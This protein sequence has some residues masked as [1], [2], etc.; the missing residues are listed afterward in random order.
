MYNSIKINGMKGFTLIELM[1][2][3]VIIGILAAIAIPAYQDYIVRSRSVELTQEL[4][5]LVKAESIAF[6]DSSVGA[7]G[8]YQTPTFFAAPQTP[9]SVP[10][11]TKVVTSNWSSDPNWAKLGFSIS[12]PA[13]GTYEAYAGSTGLIGTSVVVYA[14][15][16]F[17]ADAAGDCL[18]AHAPT[19]CMAY[20]RDITIVNGGASASGL[21]TLGTGK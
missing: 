4:D 17:D 18:P 5:H 6:T 9:S 1:I 15:A 20:G 8:T 11:G 19:N 7:N 3:V 13:A 10:V 21:Q 14:Q 2:V 16:D 12:D